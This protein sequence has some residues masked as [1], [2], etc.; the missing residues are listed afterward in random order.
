MI[1]QLSVHY[2]LSVAQVIFYSIH[3][4]LLFIQ[5]SFEYTGYSVFGIRKAEV[6]L[7]PLNLQAIRFISLCWALK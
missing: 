6:P 7:F 1:D 4:L 5:F 3:D 2:N